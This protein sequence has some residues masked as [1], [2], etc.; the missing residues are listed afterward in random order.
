MHND[1]SQLTDD[2]IISIIK[3]RHTDKF[4]VAQ[5]AESKQQLYFITIKNMLAQPKAYSM[6]KHSGTIREL[7]FD[8]HMGYYRVQFQNENSKTVKQRVHRL[9]FQ[10][11]AEPWG[12]LSTRTFA[13]ALASKIMYIH[14]RNEIRTDNSLINLAL[15]SK[16]L[17]DKLQANLKTFSVS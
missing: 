5:F 7:S 15:V 3:N 8:H 14:H 17:H 1:S 13:N 6:N 10:Y 4:H 16:K 9:V 12:R 2:Q 11:F